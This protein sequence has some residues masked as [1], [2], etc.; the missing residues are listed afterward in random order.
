MFFFIKSKTGIKKIVLKLKT[1]EIKKNFNL[2]Q[3]RYHKISVSKTISKEI[4]SYKC[5]NTVNKY[6]P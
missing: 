6:S 4:I 1:K 5:K 2:N 3:F